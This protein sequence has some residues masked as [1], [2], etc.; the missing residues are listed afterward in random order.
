MAN[1]LAIDV[2]RN[3]LYLSDIGAF[4]VRIYTILPNHHLTQIGS[5]HVSTVTDN[6]FVDDRGDVWIGGHPS[7]F[8]ALVYFTDINYYKSPSHVVRIQFDGVGEEEFLKSN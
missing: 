2:K 1:G 4:S 7:T 6:L 5:I 3:R 8:L